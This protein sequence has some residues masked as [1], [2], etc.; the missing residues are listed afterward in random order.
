[1]YTRPLI[2]LIIKPKSN[3]LGTV[4]VLLN[5]PETA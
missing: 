3:D 2:E 5:S 4:Y 1:M